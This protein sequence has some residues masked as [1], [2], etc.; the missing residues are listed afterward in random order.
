MS[1]TKKSTPLKAAETVEAA[2]TVS[3]EAVKK[4][5]EVNTEVPAK[6]AEKIIKK[7]KASEETMAK[8]IK[9]GNEP[10]EAYEDVISY[11]KDNFDAVLSA[12]KVFAKGIEAINQELFSMMQDSFSENA[13]TAQKVLSCTTVQ[14]VVALQN[15]LFT[16]SYSKTLEQSKKI[17]DLTV[18]A[19]EDTTVPISKRMNVTVEKFVKPIA[20]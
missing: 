12:N 18:K 20:A 3:P 2:V 11:G 16:Q 8:V 17:T 13:T 14:D 10:F 7:S 4:T 19:V 9:V 5:V 1:A 6:K 15:D